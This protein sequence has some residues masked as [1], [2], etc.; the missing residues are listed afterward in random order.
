[1]IYS[2]CTDQR[3]QLVAQ[4]DTLNGIDF[5]EVADDP[6]LPADQRQRTLH[7]RFLKPDHVDT[8]S[9]GQL[10]IDG[11]ERIRP[12]TVESA[13]VD[14]QD[15]RVLVVTVNRAGDFSV[16]TLRLVKNDDPAAPPPPNFDPQ[17]AAVD[18]SFKVDCPSDFDCEP[19]RVCPPEVQPAPDLDYL[20][21]D[22]ASF[23][24]MML[25]RMALLMPAWRERSPA[26]AGVALV[27]LLAYVAD[28]LSY[29][30]DAVATEAYLHT[31]R[32]RVSVRRHARLVDYP[33]HDGCNARVWV[34]VR[35]VKEAPTT[36]TLLRAFDPATG[37][38][39]RLLTKC[40][41]DDIVAEAELTHVL[42]AHH[43]EVFEL[44][45]DVE[46][47]PQHNE[48]HFHTW[49]E[50]ECCLPQGATRATLAGRLDRLKQGD[51]LIF[52][53]MVGPR[54]G[55]AGDADPTH[56]HA[57]RLAADP[58][59]TTDPL[60]KDPDDAAKEFPI[61]EI[62]W[63]AADAL[64]F[65][66]CLSAIS[67]EAHGRKQVTNVS[68]ARGNIVLADHG[69]TLA[70]EPL[71]TVPEPTL[72]YAAA[73][74]DPCAVDEPVAVPPRFAPSLATGPITQ[75]AAYDPATSTAAAHARRTPLA[76]AL[77]AV[78]LTSLYKGQTTAWTP[79]RDLLNSRADD[80]NFVV[81]VESDGTAHVRF[82]DDA[83]G[84]RPD[85]GTEFS[86]VYRVGN[87]VAGNVG[88][89]SVRHIVTNVS[90][91]E[92]V[93]NPLPA[94][95]GTEPES[96]ETVRRRAPSAFRT[97]ARAVTPA[98]YATVT[99]S[100]PEIQ[101]AAASLRWTGSWRT[102]FVTADRMGGLPVDADFEGALC[103]H[104]EPFRMAGHDVEIDGPRYVALEI[105]MDVCVAPGY[106]RSHVKA[107]LL[108]VFSSRTLPDG[109][110]GLFHPDNFSFGQPVYLSR[111]YAAA[112]GVD[113]VQS[114]QITQFERMGTPDP[115]PLADGRLDFARLEIPRLDNDP[116]FRE[117]GV[118]HL[119]V[120][121]GK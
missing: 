87:G 58:L 54:S 66:L 76:A 101:R 44:L 33:M 46:L 52:E 2:C 117:R 12:V 10:R 37:A 30:Q 40:V 79:L 15:A 110:R 99:E 108:A 93:R 31:A 70:D 72:F 85:G 7:V 64:P 27:E 34:H 17:L 96:M 82:G 75:T 26:D 43:P 83:N 56:R 23:R 59:L 73:Q 94:Q 36:G 60:F 20:A 84:K 90:A 41:D 92:R 67:D 3:R 9:A 121:G 78:R 119:T 88:A 111:L 8:L 1:M 103:R 97:Q 49:G 51:V 13:A 68:V 6:T 104:V 100:Y 112:H 107:A 57:V 42:R 118:F 38:R 5:L 50:D 4:H 98:D 109:R 39:T 89:E 14:A 102:V 77:P 21:K 65:P 69:R 53:E 18:F 25:D 55:E 29:Q 32:R 19:V 24:R 113:G 61:T 91:V 120:R 35:A 115:Q 11:G 74:G 16:Y 80:P 28:R 114:V 48:L 62:A 86:A 81:E 45:H 63:T 116:N 47:Y 106:F 105:T 95:G 22:Y 71:G